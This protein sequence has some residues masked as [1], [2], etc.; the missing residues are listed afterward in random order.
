MAD[1]SRDLPPNN[2]PLNDLPLAAVNI[3]AGGIYSETF[4][5]Y[6]FHPEAGIQESEYNFIQ[7][8]DLAHRFGRQS[9]DTFTVVEIGFGSGLNCLLTENCW[10]Q[11]RVAGKQLH[12]LCVEKYPLSRTQLAAIYRQNHWQL[13]A[14]DAMLSCYP[15]RK[16]GQHT[17]Q[18]TPNM[19]ISWWFADVCAVHSLG[20]SV[21]AWFLDGFAPQRNPAMWSPQLF[22]LMARHSHANST[23]ATFTAAGFVRRGLQAAGFVVNKHP[24]FG[25]KR[26]RLV[27]HY[28]EACCAKGI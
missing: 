14:I 22:E 27:G 12:Y 3:D 1:N 4:A 5:D 24:G 11:H 18:L 9:Q 7:G 2:L 28:A 10:Q 8:N 13:P 6:Y 23:F 20:V 19:Q 21:D 16:A 26:E 15:P 25:Q 17:Q